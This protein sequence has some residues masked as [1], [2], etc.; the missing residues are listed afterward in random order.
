[1]IDYIGFRE[2]LTNLINKQS[3]ENGSDTQD[4]VLAN[5]LTACLVAFDQAVNERDKLKLED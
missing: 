3:M 1:M 4:F 5:Y 2:E